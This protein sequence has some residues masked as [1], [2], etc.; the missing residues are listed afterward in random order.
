MLTHE[1]WVNAGWYYPR[2]ATPPGNR[3]GV[4]RGNGRPRAEGTG[5]P[6]DGGEFSHGLSAAGRDGKARIGAL[7]TAPPPQSVSSFASVRAC[8]DSKLTPGASSRT[9]NPRGVTSSTARLV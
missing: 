3:R 7:M 1:A 6:G 2:K 9:A 8:S 4:D 5:L